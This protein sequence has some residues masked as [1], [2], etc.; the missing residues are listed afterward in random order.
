MLHILCHIM[1]LLFLPKPLPFDGFF[2]EEWFDTYTAG[3]R[4]EVT[5][6]SVSTSEASTAAPLTSLFQVAFA[7]ELFLS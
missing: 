7:D 2:V 4:S 5:A 1:H 6:Q 3:F